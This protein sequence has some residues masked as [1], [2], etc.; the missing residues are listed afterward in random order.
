MKSFNNAFDFLSYEP[1]LFL[2]NSRRYKN[3][4]SAVVSLL[5]MSSISI[6]S[7]YF[8]IE[9]FQ[10]KKANILMRKSDEYYPYIN[11]TDY[12]FMSYLLYG[13]ELP[14]DPSIVD[15]SV[16]AMSYKTITSADGSSVDDFSYEVLSYTA[17]K[18]VDFSKYKYGNELRKETT[19]YK[20]SIEPGNNIT[21]SG[22]YGNTLAGHTYLNFYISECVNSTESKVV[23]K[24]K[25]GIDAILRDVY[26]YLNHPK[27]SIDHSLKDSMF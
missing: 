7:G 15:V 3:I 19:S 4:Y 27:F 8:I 1:F 23:C 17:C 5:V 22:K 14:V 11:L 10:H 9:L 12:P 18:N 21:I 24:P 20:Y 16:L 26:F 25:E 6:L 13:D 2:D